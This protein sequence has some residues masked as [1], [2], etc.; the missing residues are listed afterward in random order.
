MARRGSV[1]L[2]WGDLAAFKRRT[3][4]SNRFGL[5]AA[6]EAVRGMR[7]YVPHRDGYLEQGE[8]EPFKVRYT[9]P[10]AKRQYYGKGFNFSKEKNPRATAYWDRAFMANNG[11]AYCRALSEYLKRR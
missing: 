11:R 6:S 9:V 7:P 4:R 8:P 5:F 2:I 3:Y 1:E 10:Y